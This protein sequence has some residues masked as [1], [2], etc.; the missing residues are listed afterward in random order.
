[1]QKCC[2]PLVNALTQIQSDTKLTPRVPIVSGRLDLVL[3]HTCR[4]TQHIRYQTDLG[5]GMMLNG[6]GRVAPSS[7]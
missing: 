4:L 7:K 1:M 3:L 5:L 6:G 2:P